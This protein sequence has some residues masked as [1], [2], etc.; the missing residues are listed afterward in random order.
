MSEAVNNQTG[1]SAHERPP[2]AE[3][4]LFENRIPVI[5]IFA[6]LTAFF[7]F[8]A[9]QL[10]PD[11]SFE[12]MIPTSHPYIQNYLANKA[13]LA[14]LSNSIRII[15]ESTD[16]DIF[17]KDFQEALRLI[18]DEVFY[19]PGVDRSGLQSIWTP[20][21]RW[22]EVTEEGFRGGTVIPNAYDGSAK[23][24]DELRANILRSGQVGRLVANNFKSSAII[25]PLTDINPETGEKLDYRDFSQSLETLVR[26]K[27]ETDNIKI[28]ITGFAKVVGDLIEG[29]TLVA[30]FFGV[31][32][33][34]TLVL[35]A[36]Y[37]R[38]LY[39]TVVPITCS[40]VA[41]IWQLGLLH[42]LGFGLD[43]YSMLVP[44]LVFAIGIS[45]GVQIINNIAVRFFY[46][47]GAFWSARR[48]FR[49]LYIPGLVA[50]VS[51]GIGFLTLMVIKIPVIQ[52]LALTASIGV[53]V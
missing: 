5:I 35:L 15:V 26:D 38:C 20:N 37:S 16:G 8:Q 9:A 22:N 28:H 32:L 17:D 39:A 19:V 46:G 50:L 4:L 18:N 48:A 25:A 1:L 41:V 34:T 7:A 12:K 23:S 2:L 31:A 47:A 10:K 45:H 29:A 49:V 27:Y 36:I 44:F 33:V 11:A 51:D 14:S 30:L 24:L 43:P 6:L 52:E 21:V 53:A 3:R 13:D 40:T 42:T